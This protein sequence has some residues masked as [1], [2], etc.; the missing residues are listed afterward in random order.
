MKEVCWEI[1][2]HILDFLVV[3]SV[4]WLSTCKSNTAL[5]LL[6]RC[7]AQMYGDQISN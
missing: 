2:G 5:L 7:M 6:D 4:L 3:F 1:D